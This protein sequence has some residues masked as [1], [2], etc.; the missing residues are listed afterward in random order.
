[1]RVLVVDDSAAVR[2]RLLSWLGESTRIEVREAV[3]PRDALARLRATAADLVLLDLHLGPVAGSRC[4]GPLGLDLIGRI[5]RALPRV[6]V[7]VL[8]NAAS[9]SHRRECLRLGADYFFDKSLEFE[10]AIE[11]IASQAASLL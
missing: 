8:S 6:L 7:V 1:M 11:L 10:R 2:Q 4:G 9:E 5:K 3:H